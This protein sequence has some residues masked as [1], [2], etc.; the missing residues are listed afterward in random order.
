MIYSKIGDRPGP[1]LRFY[2]D[3]DRIDRRHDAALILRKCIKTQA[4][5]TI[6]RSISVDLQLCDVL[7]LRRNRQNETEK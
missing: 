6:L 7:M 4:T 2:I 1:I 5:L 3:R